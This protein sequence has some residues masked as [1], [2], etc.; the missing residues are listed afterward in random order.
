MTP[1]ET[2]KLTQLVKDLINLKR[3]D[4][5]IENEPG[6]SS[7]EFYEYRTG[8]YVSYDDMEYVIRKLISEFKI[9]K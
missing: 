7:V 8:N 5:E 6:S 4:A 3:Y 2:L 9:K 1:Q